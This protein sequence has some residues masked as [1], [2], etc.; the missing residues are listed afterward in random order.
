MFWGLLW[1]AGVKIQLGS[2]VRKFVDEPKLIQAGM[3]IA[4]SD[5]CLARSVSKLGYLGV[6]SG[7]AIDSV[8]V[9]RLQMGDRGGHIQRALKHF[10]IPEMAN[11]LFQKYF[12]PDKP[13][14]KAFVRMPLMRVKQT[15]EYQEL[16][17]VSNFVEVFLAKE[18]H[19][20]KVAV[21]YLEKIQMPIL[22]SAYGAMLAGVD[23]VIMG[24]G[25]PREVPV[26]LNQLS[27]HEDA[28]YKVFVIGAT[29]QDDF[30]LQFS[31]RAIM[32]DC[33]PKLKRPK[34]LAIVASTTLATLMVKKI[35][36]P[37]DG[38]II[39]APSAGGHN[40]PPRVK[41]QFNSR[42][43]PLYGERDEV[44]LAAVAALGVPFWLAGTRASVQDVRDAFEKGATGVQIG[45]AFAL[46]EESGLSLQYRKVLLEKIWE[47]KLDIFT[48]GRGSPTGFPFKVALLEGSNSDAKMYA[49]RTRI[50]DLGYLRDAYR[51]ADGELGYRCSSE[52]IETFIKS[53]GALED[54]VGRKCL[55]NGLMANIDLAQ[56][57]A[58]EEFER[59]IVTLGDDVKSVRQFIN[60]SKKSYS[61]SEVIDLLAPAFPPSEL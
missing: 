35:P 42:G 52:P 48:D 14:H 18:G 47:N 21:N 17:I 2:S 39:E 4:V 29:A 33:L 20:G 38:L 7:T 58:T 22:P 23:Y 59:P 8:F 6:V 40:A 25:I 28:T 49:E 55:C 26:V 57:Q 24:A 44:D 3:G 36:V 50:C 34:F 37:V 45:T 1:Q 13:G 43:E 54:T 46:C 61:A 31:P 32:G 19:E 41:L 51:K 11:R 10:P 27:K 30:R 15:R 5:W 12:L 56:W 53:G 16:L 9:R 60:A